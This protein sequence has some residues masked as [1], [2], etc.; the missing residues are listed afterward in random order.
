MVFPTGMRVQGRVRGRVRGE[1]FYQYI[2]VL[3]GA[4]PSLNRITWIAKRSFRFA[5]T[6]A[7]DCFCGGSWWWI[8]VLVLIDWNIGGRY[9][10]C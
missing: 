1:V 5:K 6:A 2:G 9:L 7:I 10:L 4:G 3:S 8:V